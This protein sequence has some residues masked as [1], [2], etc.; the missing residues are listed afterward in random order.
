MRE[1]GSSITPP[2]P[3]RGF[4]KNV[5][6]KEK[7]KLWFL[8]T[9]FISFLEFLALG[10]QPIKK[11]LRHR[12]CLWILLNIYEHIFIENIWGTASEKQ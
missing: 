8:L 4:S 5:F 12:C 7:V 2:P 1:G 9:I 3:G 10:L 11:R 6:F